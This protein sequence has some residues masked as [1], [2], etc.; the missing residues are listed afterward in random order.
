MD[1]KNYN[2]LYGKKWAVCG[3]SFTNGD[4]NNAL[5]NDIYIEDGMYKGQKKVYGYLIANR[6]EM[7]VQHLALGGRTMATPPDE[8]FTN[9]FSYDGIY[10][11][12]D[13]DVDYI[14]LYFGINDSHHRQR[15]TASDGEDT[16]GVIALGTIEDTD[17]STFYGAWNVV[18]EY[19]ITNYPY[20]KIGIIISNGCE[21]VDYPNA[22]IAIARKWGVP[23]LDLNSDYQVPMMNRTNGRSETCAKAL[24]VRN[25][26]FA[27]NYGVNNHPNAKAHEYISTFIENWLRSL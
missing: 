19:L 18:M 6:N 20:A 16:S 10:N 5:D 2:V 7:Q 17:A 23:Y 27:V 24:E 22:E 12:I 9:C 13:K 3:D 8:S 21:T 14:T 4:F 26:N 15:A 1:S 25:R 11:S